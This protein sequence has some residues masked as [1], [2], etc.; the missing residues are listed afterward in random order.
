MPPQTSGS[1]ACSAP[2]NSCPHNNSATAVCCMRTTALAL[3]FPFKS[4][5][6]PLVNKKTVPWVPHDICSHMPHSIQMCV[7]APHLCAHTSH[8]FHTPHNSALTCSSTSV[9]AEHSSGTKSSMLYCGAGAS[10][11]TLP[12]GASVGQAVWRGACQSTC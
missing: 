2:P 12:A 4:I 1:A 5:H 7:W 6:S 10:Y 3:F 8:I 9:P 11:C